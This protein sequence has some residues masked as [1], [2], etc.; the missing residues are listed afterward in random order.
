MLQLTQITCCLHARYNTARYIFQQRYLFQTEFG[1]VWISSVNV[2]FVCSKLNIKV[3]TNPPPKCFFIYLFSLCWTQSSRKTFLSSSQNDLNSSVLPL[4]MVV[5]EWTQ[6]F[7]PS[8]STDWMLGCFSSFH[9]HQG[10]SVTIFWYFDQLKVNVTH[11]FQPVVLLLTIMLLVLK[12][13]KK[14]ISVDL[15]YCQQKCWF[16]RFP[17]NLLSAF[18]LAVA[19]WWIT[20]SV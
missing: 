17:W 7:L 5:V 2:I 12:K 9:Y 14:V 11:L 20:V 15:E 18:L 8:A 10:K 1:Y 6:S 19:T 3:M 4:K 13:K 16:Q